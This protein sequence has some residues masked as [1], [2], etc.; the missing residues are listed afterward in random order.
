VLDGAPEPLV[1]DPGGAPG[2]LVLLEV[3]GGGGDAHAG[4]TGAEREVLNLVEHGLTNDEIAA[5]RCRSRRT[6]AKQVASLLAKHGVH[7]RAELF[8]LLASPQIAP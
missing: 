1:Q 2:D 7:C 3:R 6:V 8:A 4:L 5:C